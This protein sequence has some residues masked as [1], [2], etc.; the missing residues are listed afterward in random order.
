M[1]YTRAGESANP[2]FFDTFVVIDVI[3]FRHLIKNAY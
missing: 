3:T 1:E 2:S